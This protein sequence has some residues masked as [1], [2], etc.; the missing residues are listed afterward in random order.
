[1]RFIVSVIIALVIIGA[2]VGIGVG[3]SRATH[4]EVWAG[5]G[6]SKPIE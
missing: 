4:G 3:V 2:A 6:K 5:R 1:M